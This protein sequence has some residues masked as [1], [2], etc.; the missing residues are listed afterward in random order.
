MFRPEQDLSVP[1]T[2]DAVVL[3]CRTHFGS[4]DAYD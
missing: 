4:T 1:Q 3:V 2:V